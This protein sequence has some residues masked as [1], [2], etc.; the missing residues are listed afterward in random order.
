MPKEINRN[1][2]NSRILTYNLFLNLVQMEATN[3]ITK[4]ASRV[5]RTSFIIELMMK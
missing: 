2:E 5:K 3:P 1:V 4:N